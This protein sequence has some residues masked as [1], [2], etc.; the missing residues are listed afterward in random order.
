LRGRNARHLLSALFASFTYEAEVDNIPRIPKYKTC[1]FHSHSV[2]K[3]VNQINTKGGIS[4]ELRRENPEGHS[5]EG[6]RRNVK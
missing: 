6:L 5:N 4:R 1:P 3:K 2:R